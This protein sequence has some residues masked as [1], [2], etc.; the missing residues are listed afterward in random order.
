MDNLTINCGACRDLLPLVAEGMASDESIALTEAHLNAC[1]DCRAELERIRETP[2]PVQLPLEGSMRRAKR[3]LQRR[4]II[5]LVLA[6]CLL[7]TVGGIAWSQPI[8][9]PYR[10]S[11]FDKRVMEYGVDEGGGLL[12]F[13]TGTNRRFAPNFGPN[14]RMMGDII[15]ED[16]KEFYVVYI[17]WLQSGLYA[18]LSCIYNVKLETKPARLGIQGPIGETIM[19][20]PLEARYAFGGVNLAGHEKVDRVYYYPHRGIFGGGDNKN[21]WSQRV[22]VLSRSHL[23][24]DVETAGK[25]AQLPSC[26]IQAS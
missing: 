4:K 3:K 26:I 6:A 2:A 21:G 8:Y 11:Y 25:P 17:S 10:K 7:L 19:S 12:R 23:I 22:A 18:F 15:E 13:H 1:E 14:M 16:G 24:W 20:L 9:L 5:S